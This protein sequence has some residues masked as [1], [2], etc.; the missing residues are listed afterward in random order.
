MDFRQLE[1]FVAVVK[2]KS[3]T[4]AAEKTFVSQSTISSHVNSLEKELH[5]KLFIR[6]TKSV[7]VT[8]R[9]Q[10]LYEYAVS[11][12]KI[13]NRMME[14]SA[15]NKNVV[16]HLG[17]ST[18]PSAYVLPNV[19]LEYRERKPN[20]NFTIYQNDSQGILS[21][22]QDGV[23]DIGIIGMKC[24]IDE[25]ICTP[26]CKD[27]MVLVTP[28]NDYFLSLKGNVEQGIAEALKSPIILREDGSGSQKSIELFLNSMDIDENE[29]N[30]VARMNDQEAIKR[31]V[32]GGMGVSIMSERAVQTLEQY[33]QALVF[34]LPEELST[35]YFY[36]IYRRKQQLKG[37]VKEFITFLQTWLADD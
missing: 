15:F 10:D 26:L 31:L 21:N 12:M 3:F 32:A 20:V 17:A 27:R 24:D 13:R 30:I 22:L 25:L 11:I 14:Y 35:R 9:G 6:S 34:E 5:E 33:K 36:L 8:P 29:L 16:I 23:F 2:Y 37:H 18:I 7:K 4:K 28:Y 1:A 19:L